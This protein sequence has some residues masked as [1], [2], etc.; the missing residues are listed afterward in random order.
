M[1]RI[2][3]LLMT[4]VSGFI[5]LTAFAAPAYA[6][7]LKAGSGA[8]SFIPTWYEYLPGKASTTGACEVDTSGGGKTIVLI[9]MGIFD[10]ILFFAGLLAVIMVMYGGY[11]LVTSTGEPQK[12]AAGRT[13]IINSLV[14]LVIAIIASQIVGFIAGKLS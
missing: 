4:M 7:E 13:T 8:P 5:L 6:C 12:I 3:L 14:G 1:K 2:R 11:K 9:L 10:I